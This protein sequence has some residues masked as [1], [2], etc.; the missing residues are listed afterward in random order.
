MSKCTCN[1]ETDI[2]GDKLCWDCATKKRKCVKCSKYKPYLDYT[3]CKKCQRDEFGTCSEQ[4]C[5]SP[6]DITNN[7]YFCEKHAGK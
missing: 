6:I 1:E 7:W 4:D 5:L 3:L 2:E